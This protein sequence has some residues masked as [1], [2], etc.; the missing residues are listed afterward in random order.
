MVGREETI[1][2]TVLVLPFLAVAIL[3]SFISGELKNIHK[4][5]VTQRKQTNFSRPCDFFSH[6]FVNFISRLC[7]ALCTW[8]FTVTFPFYNKIH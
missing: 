4:T 1:F 3:F 8:Q 5:L 2:N 6:F 7:D